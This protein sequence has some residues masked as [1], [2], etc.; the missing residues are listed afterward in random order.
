MT[1]ASIRSKVL[2]ASI[3]CSKLKARTPCTIGKIPP[4]FISIPCLLL[5]TLP[6]RVSGTEKLSAGRVNSAKMSS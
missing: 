2:L 5:F 4:C 6:N 3:A 1:K